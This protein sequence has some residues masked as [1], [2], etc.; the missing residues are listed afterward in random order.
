VTT[1]VIDQDAA[2]DLRRDAEEVRSILPI[3][4]ALI[5]ET[6]E[7]LM[8]K[9]RRLQRVVGSLLPQLARGHASQL[10]VDKRQ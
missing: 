10:R 4:L 7:H 5:D 1:G 6:D 8:D 9:G 2:H 3:G